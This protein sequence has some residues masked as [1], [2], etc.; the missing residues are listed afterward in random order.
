LQ[1]VYYCCY[2]YLK[3]RALIII[4]LSLHFSCKCYFASNIDL[5]I[6]Y[7]IAYN[8]IKDVFKQ[9]NIYKRPLKVYK[10]EAE[11]KEAVVVLQ[12]D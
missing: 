2:N 9:A 3:A 1:I 6:S 10:P 8:L 5:L 4:K 7:I 12:I 11:E